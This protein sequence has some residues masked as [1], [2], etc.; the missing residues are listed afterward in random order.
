MQREQKAG[1]GCRKDPYRAILTHSLSTYYEN[2]Y[3]P[4]YACAF[5][6]Q[7]SLSREVMNI[8]EQKKRT[9]SQTVAETSLKTTRIPNP[10]SENLHT[11]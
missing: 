2:K 11:R 7:I 10:S 1:T 4:A 9:L 6:I 3:S 8:E 5:K